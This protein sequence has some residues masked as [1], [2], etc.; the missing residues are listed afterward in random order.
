MKHIRLGTNL[1]LHI[2]KMALGLPELKRCDLLLGTTL[3][4]VTTCYDT[5][6]VT[7]DHVTGHLQSSARAFRRFHLALEFWAPAR[8]DH[9]IYIYPYMIL[10]DMDPV[11]H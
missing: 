6:A 3:R 8:R 10:C 4:L 11:T 2:K 7:H 5:F 1:V 9:V